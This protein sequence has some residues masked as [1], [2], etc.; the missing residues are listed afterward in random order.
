MKA[1]DLQKHLVVIGGVLIFGFLALGSNTL[2]HKPSPGTSLQ[3]AQRAA[4]QSVAMGLVYY[5]QM[6]GRPDVSRYITE[7]QRQDLKN[8]R[9]RKSQLDFLYFQND[10]MLSQQE[11]D[12]MQADIRAEQE[13]A[14]EERKRQLAQEES[15]RTQ[16]L[17]RA[18]QQQMA[19][20]KRAQEQVKQTKSVVETGARKAQQ[21]NPTLLQKTN[22]SLFQQPKTN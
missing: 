2:P 9:I 13:A 4:D 5:D 14:F 22:P 11:V 16:A 19:A 20:E 1:A 3:Q 18:A 7:L 21:P 6:P 8:R 12:R 10:R 17:I 15:D